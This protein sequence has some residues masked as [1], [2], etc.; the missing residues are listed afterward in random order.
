V[1][2]DLLELM[3]MKM[4]PWKKAGAQLLNQ[5][6]EFLTEEDQFYFNSAFNGVKNG[7]E[8]L[9]EYYLHKIFFNCP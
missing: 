4:G 6:G 7:I 2:A 8:C 1:K 3:K 5:F 9:Y